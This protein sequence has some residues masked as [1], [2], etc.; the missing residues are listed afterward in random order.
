[1]IQSRFTRTGARRLGDEYQDLIALEVLIDWLGHSSRYKWVL[2]EAGEAGYLDDVVALRSDDRLVVRQVKFSTD[3]EK[4]ED[5]WTWDDLLDKPEGK[6]GKANTSLLEKWSTSLSKLAEQF[7]IEDAAVVSNRKASPEIE[8]C[9]SLDGLIDFD[10]ISDLATRQSIIQQIGGEDKARVFFSMFRFRLNEPGVTELERAIRAKFRRLG[11][12][13]EGWLNLKEELRFWVHYRNEPAPDGKITLS[14]IRNAALWY[15]LRELPQSF[16]IPSDYVLP[17]Q[18]FHER[19]VRDLLSI[20]CG[21]RVLTASPGVG[22]STYSSKLYEQLKS[23]NVP[24]IRHHYYLSSKDTTA[25]W[26]LDHQRAAES[27]MHDLQSDCFEALEAE[28]VASENP[29]Y[30]DLRKW[31]EACGRYYQRQN[32]SLIIIIDGLDH[33]WRDNKSIEE[34]TKLLGFILPVAEGVVVFL[35]TQP[36]DDSKLPSSLLREAPRE[37]WITLPLLDRDAVEEWL[38]HHEKGLVK[39]DEDNVPDF[40]FERLAEAFYRR[41]NGHPLHLRYTIRALQEQD[42]PITEENIERLP[43][44]AH[45][46]ITDY[47][48]ELWRTLPEEG[49]EILHLMSACRFPWPRLGILDCL[50]PQG[51]N[52]SGVTKALKQVRHMLLQDALGLRPFHSSLLVFIE[53]LSEHKDYAERMKRLALKWLRTKAP[54]RWSWA[55]EWSLEA[56]LGNDQSLCEQPNRKWTIESLAKRRPRQEIE[57]MLSRSTWYALQ[58]RNLPRA[59]EVGLIRGY[60]SDAFDFHREPLELLLYPQLILKDDPLLDAGLLSDLSSLTDGE[61]TL[62]AEEE[63]EQGNML[64]VSKCFE[65]LRDR[66]NNGRSNSAQGTYPDWQ[67]KITPIVRVAAIYS[68]YEPAKLINFAI[69]HRDEGHSIR[70][71]SIFAEE[72]RVR[73]DIARLRRTLRPLIDPASDLRVDMTQDERHAILRQAVLLALEEGIDLDAEVRDE[74]NRTEPL[75]AV[76]AAIRKFSDFPAKDFN[77]PNANQLSYKR[78]E[79]YDKRSDLKQL[80]Y[81]TFFAL[82]ANHLWNRSERND[83]WLRTI[84]NST[85][86]QR[87]MQKLNQTARELAALISTNSKFSSE[88]LYE[89]LKEVKRPDKPEE[90]EV[91][92]LGYVNIMQ[93]VVIQ[94]ALDLLVFAK[95]LGQEPEISQQ[96]M[97]SAFSSGYCNPQIWIPAYVARRRRWLSQTA[98]NWLLRKQQNQ[99]ASSI[100]EFPER[101]LQYG[102]LAATAALHGVDDEARHFINI[103]AENLVA[104]GHHKDVLFF[105]IFEVIQVCHKAGMPEA[106]QWLL[107][108]APAIAH[109]REYTDSDE[110]GALSQEM[111]N[112]LAEVA[113]DLLPAYYK[114]LY[115]KEEWRD[116]IHTFRLFIKTA[117]LFDP[118][119][120]AVAKTAVDQ[121]CL[122]ILAERTRAGDNGAQEVL[123]SLTELLGENTLSKKSKEETESGGS[124]YDK[125]SKLSP[126]DYPPEQFSEYLKGLEAERAFWPKENIERWANWWMK[127]DQGEAVLHAL[128]AAEKRGVEVRCYDLM[129]DLAL[130]LYGKE[131]AYPWLVRAHQS[132]YGWSSYMYEKEIAVRRWEMVEKYYP[133]RWFDFIRDTMKSEYGASWHKLSI[134]HRSFQ[135][136]V[137]Y[138]LRMGQPETAKRTAERMISIALELVSPVNLPLPEWVQH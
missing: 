137:E 106:R 29:N 47:Y 96:D 135:R 132:E 111:S 76:Y 39:F 107:Q 45:E 21:C 82:L 99:L 65:E 125:E 44:C 101:A 54:E 35:A 86:P 2:V 112:A 58:H 97:E 26:R 12:T 27:L 22:K 42:I 91:Y 134:G 90:D 98:L 109:V 1:M 118:V 129:F 73:K 117:D 78:Y 77:F 18:D 34:L 92:V 70:I 72:L 64:N 108:I 102:A 128:E 75:A 28:G 48:A 138:C 51:M 20:R 61:I 66:I 15:Q 30:H 33:V 3:P 23:Q 103:A 11:G 113:P 116:A 57:D 93:E 36:V 87:F 71:L 124:N 7:A 130:S 63:Y 13:D 52:T 49:R 85:W 104:H 114:W 17:S 53:S 79:Q 4:P 31:I 105:G 133:E 6:S 9:L 119:N 32:K 16:E 74:E 120:Q 83:A 127:N 25:V 84:G 14:E 68:E 50:D 69:A 55:Y 67:S 123:S 136:L 59:V 122:E 89:K 95:A 100:E 38:R 121:R 19:L 40:L 110:T 94:I 60:C 126:S 88:L 24:I 131:R 37:Q 81:S 8:Q 46:N 115:A 56:D 43:G 62:L 80:F 5:P 41:S 10:K